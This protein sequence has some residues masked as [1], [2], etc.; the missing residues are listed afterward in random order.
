MD[1][2]TRN[3]LIIIGITGLLV[4]AA[5]L[6]SLNPR[7]W[8]LNDLLEN[9]PQ[10]SNYPYQFR[11]QFIKGKMAHITSPRSPK[12]PA[13]RFLAI[14]FPNLSG[15]SDNNPDVIQAQK[16]LGA[17][18]SRAKKLILDQPDISKV[19]WVIDQSWYSQHGIMLQ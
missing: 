12:V 13:V 5:W 11:V 19:R 2:M 1:R 8:E 9:D 17:I 10:L 4:V 7:V 6:P 3:Y 18:Q 16:E 15:K 14:I